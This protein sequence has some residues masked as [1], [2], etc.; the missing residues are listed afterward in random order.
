MQCTWDAFSDVSLT[1][2]RRFEI[3]VGQGG[4][5]MLV[6][7]D[8]RDKVECI[9]DG[10]KGSSSYS[11]VSDT[12]RSYIFQILFLLQPSARERHEFCLFE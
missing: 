9:D 5:D 3:S 8:T 2:R 12:Q 7:I 4:Q 1:Q 10:L 6:A 11:Q